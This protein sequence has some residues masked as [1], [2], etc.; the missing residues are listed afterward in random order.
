MGSLIV[1]NMKPV[2]S[3]SISETESLGRLSM[4]KQLSPLSFRWVVREI[5]IDAH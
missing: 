5:V 4:Q 3:T 2:D 1:L